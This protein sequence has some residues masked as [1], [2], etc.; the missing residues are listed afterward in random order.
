MISR[1]VRGHVKWPS[2]KKK[3]NK[4]VGKC[5]ENKNATG[6]ILVQLDHSNLV[7]AIRCHVLNS[8]FDF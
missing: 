6:R 5:M 2:G 3:K 4:T 7:I 1:G 8:E